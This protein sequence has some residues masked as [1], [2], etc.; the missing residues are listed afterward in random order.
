MLF[1]LSSAFYWSP[2]EFT[3]FVRQKRVGEDWNICGWTTKALECPSLNWLTLPTSP[4]PLLPTYSFCSLCHFFKNF[5]S[6]L[7][8]LKPLQESEVWSRLWKC[9]PYPELCSR[10][11]SN[12]DIIKTCWLQIC[13]LCF[14]VSER[15]PL[16]LTLWEPKSYSSLFSFLKMLKLGRFSW[17][18]T[19]KT[20]NNCWIF[21]FNVEFHWEKCPN[22]SLKWQY[23]MKITSFF[24]SFL[25]FCQ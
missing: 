16:K 8:V 7:C 18:E 19:V 22:L 25:F 2:P 1:P 24:I 13:W 20:E 3:S 17:A 12:L 11:H 5:I 4:R 9:R 21:N 6:L 10:V 15:S 14:R 23:F